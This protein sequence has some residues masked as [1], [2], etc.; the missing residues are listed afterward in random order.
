MY[1]DVKL[2]INGEWCN[3][4]EGK[5]EPIINPATGQVLARLAHAS[6]ADLD[7]A[8]HAADKGF[9]IWRKV[10]AFDRYK[11]L[12]KAADII[13]SRADEIAPL[14]TQEQGKPLAEAKMETLLAG[15]IM[16]WF[17]EEARR[18]YGRVVPSRAEG[19]MQVVVK[20]AGIFLPTVFVL[21]GAI[22][23]NVLELHDDG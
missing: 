16:D 12:R 1:T 8:L 14:M 2:F 5:S 23:P 17:A 10:S 18:T 13:R 22:L 20:D 11:L 21:M 15:D 6:P 19:V 4:G 9:K 3:G 7:Q